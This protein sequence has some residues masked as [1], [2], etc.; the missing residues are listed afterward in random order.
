MGAGSGRGHRGGSARHS[1]R[2]QTH[3]VPPV[4]LFKGLW[5]VKINGFAPPGPPGNSGGS[6]S[7]PA[8]PSGAAPEG[9][10]TA[11]FS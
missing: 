1:T 11:R 5:I 2:Q 10:D 8:R 4:G 9:L 6:S 3:H 7:I